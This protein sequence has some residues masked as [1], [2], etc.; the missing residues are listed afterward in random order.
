MTEL[1]SYLQIVF[2]LGPEG[3]IYSTTWPCSQS[4][5]KLRSTHPEFEASVDS[6][7]SQQS[8]AGGGYSVCI[9]DL[10][11]IQTVLVEYVLK[12]LLTARDAGVAAAAGSA[13][14]ATSR[15]P[16]SGATAVSARPNCVNAHGG[17]FD[18]SDVILQLVDP[19]YL[20]EQFFN[21]QSTWRYLRD[22][23]PTNCVRP[24]DEQDKALSVGG[25]A[26][27]AS[28][29][30]RPEKVCGRGY[31]WT[32]DANRK[33]RV[34]HQHVEG[35]PD[36]RKETED[37]VQQ[38]L[39]RG[40]ESEQT[41]GGKPLFGIAFAARGVWVGKENAALWD[42]LQP[43]SSYPSDS[44]AHP[45]EKNGAPTLHQFGPAGVVC[46]GVAPAHVRG[47]ARG[48]PL[49]IKKWR[50]IVPVIDR[51]DGDVG[52][53]GT[54]GPDGGG[55]RETGST[56]NAQIDATL[57]GAVP[58]EDD[59]TQKEL[60]VADDSQ[61]D[62]YSKF[63]I[64][65]LETDT[66]RDRTLENWAA[67]AETSLTKG[68]K[69][70]IVDPVK[71]L[72]LNEET[73]A[74]VKEEL[75]KKYSE[76]GTHLN[77]LGGEENIRLA[78][79]N[80]AKLANQL[81]PE[82]QDNA[83]AAAAAA[84]FFQTVHK[85]V[86]SFY[87]RYFTMAGAQSAAAR[88]SEPTPSPARTTRRA[89]TALERDIDAAIRSYNLRRSAD[90]SGA[91]SS[92]KLSA[93]T[94]AVC[95]KRCEQWM[96]RNTKY[97][98]DRKLISRAN[99]PTRSF[100]KNV[101]ELVQPD[102]ARTD[103]KRKRQWLRLIVDEFAGSV[104]LA[105][106]IKIG[107]SVV[108]ELKRNILKNGNS[109]GPTELLERFR[110]QRLR[111]LKLEMSKAEEELE[112]LRNLAYSAITA[113]DVSVLSFSLE[114]AVR[115]TGFCSLAEAI[116]KSHEE[117]GRAVE[118]H[119]PTQGGTLMELVKR[120]A[121]LIVERLIGGSTSGSKPLPEDEVVTTAL[122][123]AERHANAARKSRS[124]PPY[125]ARPPSVLR[126]LPDMWVKALSASEMERQGTVNYVSPLGELPFELHSPVLLGEND[127][128]LGPNPPVALIRKV[129]L[130]PGVNLTPMR[131]HEMRTRFSR[132][133][134]APAA[135]VFAAD[136]RGSGEDGDG[137]APPR[138][139]N[140][141][142][143]AL[144]KL[145]RHGL[146]HE[147]DLFAPE[148]IRADDV[149]DQDGG[150]VLP[151]AGAVLDVLDVTDRDA[152]DD[153]VA[154]DE[155]AKL[156]SG[157][158]LNRSESDIEE[159]R[160]S[161]VHMRI[162]EGYPGAI[163]KKLL[164]D[165]FRT[166]EH[167]THQPDVARMQQ[168]SDRGQC[169]AERGI[170]ED[171]F[172][173]EVEDP[174]EHP[175]WGNRYENDPSL[176]DSGAASSTES[177]SKAGS[178]SVYAD[179]HAELEE[180]ALIEDDEDVG[181]A[182]GNADD[183][184]APAVKE[185]RNL[186]RDQKAVKK[187]KHAR[188]AERNASR[189]MSGE[190]LPSAGVLSNELSLAARDLQ[191]VSEKLRAEAATGL[192]VGVGRENSLYS[193][194]TE[195]EEDTEEKNGPRAR[196]LRGEYESNMLL[197]K[198]AAT[199]G[200]G[201]GPAGGAGTTILLNPRIAAHV[202][203]ARWARN[204][205][206][207]P[208]PQARVRHPWHYPGFLLDPTSASG[209]AEQFLENV[210]AWSRTWRPE[211]DDE[212]VNIA[213]Y[214]TEDHDRMDVMNEAEDALL[215]E[216]RLLVL[217]WFGRATAIDTGD[218]ATSSGAERGVFV[219]A[220]KQAVETE[221]RFLD[222]FLP[223]LRVLQDRS[224]MAR[225]SSSLASRG[226][227]HL[228]LEEEALL[229]REQMQKKLDPAGDGSC[230]GGAP[231]SPGLPEKNDIFGGDPENKP[232]STSAILQ[233]P[234][235]HLA[236]LR[237]D[238]SAVFERV[239]DPTQES[240]HSLGG[241]LI[242]PMLSWSGGGCNPKSLRTVFEKIVAKAESEGGTPAAIPIDDHNCPLL[243]RS[244]GHLQNQEPQP[245]TEL[246]R[247]SRQAGTLS[248]DEVLAD[249][250]LLSIVET[251]AAL[252][253]DEHEST[254]FNLYA[255][256]NA[257]F[258]QP[259]ELG[260]LQ[261][262]RSVTTSARDVANLRSSMRV[263][264]KEKHSATSLGDTQAW[265]LG[266][267][268][269]ALADLAGGLREDRLRFEA[270]MRDADKLHADVVKLEEK[271]TISAAATAATSSSQGRN[272]SRKGPRCSDSRRCGGTAAPARAKRKNVS[273]TSSAGY[274]ALP[275]KQT[276]LA[277]AQQRL[278]GLGAYLEGQYRAEEDELRVEV[279][280]EPAT[281]SEV[282]GK[283]T[284]LGQP[285]QAANDALD[286]D[287]EVQEDVG[288]SH[289]GGVLLKRTMSAIGYLAESKAAV[290][291]IAEKR[292]RPAAGL[293]Q[294]LVRVLTDIATQVT[295]DPEPDDTTR[296]HTFLERLKKSFR[297]QAQHYEKLPVPK[298]D[299]AQQ[300]ASALK[301]LTGSLQSVNRTQPG[302]GFV[303]LQKLT[304]FLFARAPTDEDF[305]S[306]EGNLGMLPRFPDTGKW[307]KLVEE[308]G[309]AVDADRDYDYDNVD[310]P[311]LLALFSRE[312]A[313]ALPLPLPSHAAFKGIPRV[314][315]T[316]P[317]AGAAGDPPDASTGGD[318]AAWSDAP[319]R[320]DLS[321]SSAQEA[322]SKLRVAMRQLDG[323]VI[324][325][326]SVFVK[327]LAHRNGESLVFAERAQARAQ[328]LK[329]IAGS[330]PD[331]VLYEIRDA[332]LGEKM[333]GDADGSGSVQK[334]KA[335]NPGLRVLPPA[336][337]NGDECG[338]FHDGARE[339]SM[340]T[341][342]LT[343]RGRDGS[344]VPFRPEDLERTQRTQLQCELVRAQE[345]AI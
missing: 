243:Q 152:L 115:T 333:D 307:K 27:L 253:L 48:Y 324:R 261:L 240:I 9:V 222:E 255:W 258:G 161:L 248:L 155:T 285:R 160:Q 302:W 233:H 20:E 105:R 153:R 281:A 193:S 108:D 148:R 88:V 198:P 124:R 309:E 60:T 305:M 297:D 210:G 212:L 44:G 80:Y 181:I 163:Q 35:A 228:Q 190:V 30:P 262:I 246:Y 64:E 250:L 290:S 292:T 259:D 133:L 182:G 84:R 218:T 174:Q 58:R 91:P 31:S 196:C 138:R 54:S 334:V 75:V 61:A 213:N 49:G 162:V 299:M 325:Y 2:L 338:L 310:Y 26:N 332:I 150:D 291:Q 200:H 215:P 335:D 252:A 149:E 191:D 224:Q 316:L 183:H 318:D 136:G 275:L 188:V 331:S 205:S 172:A 59:Y 321:K 247:E 141:G 92:S 166:P 201:G 277:D 51:D 207:P 39:T 137:D 337:S 345:M 83:E 22:G 1:L 42:R 274:A 97:I 263:A 117:I 251:R 19:L 254:E 167:V 175:L 102:A 320:I 10:L 57:S 311:A 226:R 342:D 50:F 208:H 34:L 173:D 76:S 135:A 202:L 29:W 118:G 25:Y 329:L 197:P 120:K 99:A 249:D 227:G 264:K 268:E 87:E 265:S 186:D 144:R 98:W 110:E 232:F 28:Y 146:F 219:D 156:R 187:A 177:P 239:S 287:H 304:E 315:S 125:C 170:R 45:D 256:L 209:G 234:I 238:E 244:G 32:D 221:A 282:S 62:S 185:E 24:D 3:S 300:S 94:T 341:S 328:M 6:V 93:A 129:G 52:G 40:R 179:A 12:E 231:T 184:V 176:A 21:P 284:A 340:F 90:A 273:A 330:D 71:T 37:V 189:A 306:K 16:A 69:I 225:T 169:P 157:Q 257:K 344:P 121:S 223:K 199:G 81:P 134:W 192:G 107:E 216:T 276:Q 279:E 164:A 214:N 85:P 180:L 303:V 11:E 47:R 158:A 286:Q 119:Q 126:F 127:Q 147:G 128:V 272:D 295:S 78:V 18:R 336:L 100:Q 229:L 343:K 220:L 101:V 159:D 89:A 142:G 66:E 203:R 241:V 327:A 53:G 296:V 14:T 56:G 46:Q 294:N 269:R 38:M 323:V 283:A 63:L 15:T 267:H 113:S 237:G 236:L 317:T 319:W 73:R 298:V 5:V 112:V 17:V 23:V 245:D 242:L 55:A 7:C 116:R 114:R 308:F 67:H 4:E 293:K 235:V 77:E 86:Q 288:H 36:R 313:G 145:D 204:V 109:Y 111:E 271:S 103:R 151:R 96:D 301:T 195:S 178:G 154:G 70:L 339:Q 43:A 260:V 312:I 168:L 82:E 211:T 33:I 131:A 106:R 41:P 171:A 79:D 266:I 165:V 132:A 65:I 217:D 206:A 13:A 278:Q 322:A 104:E 68:S 140:A 280:Q 74:A 130:R 139:L 270:V 194:C 123:I 122:S 326:S 8:E 143:R 72:L 95:G 230:G 289:A 314:T